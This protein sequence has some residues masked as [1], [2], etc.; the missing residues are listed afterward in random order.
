MPILSHYSSCVAPLMLFLSHCR[1]SCIASFCAIVPY[2]LS[3]LSRYYSSCVVILLVLP[4]LPLCCS[5]RFTSMMHMSRCSSCIAALVLLLPC[6]SCHVAPPA[7]YLCIALFALHLFSCCHSFHV[8]IPFK[9]LF[10]PYHSSHI[11]TPLI[12]L[13][14]HC[15]TF[16]VPTSLASIVFLMMPL[17]F[18]L[19]YYSSCV[20]SL[21]C[22]VSWYCPY[23][24]HVQVGARSFDT[25][26]N[27]KGKFHC[28]FSS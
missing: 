20:I 16:Q 14:S 6:W 24:C 18:L 11:G 22:L 3:F 17:L 1:S 8:T 26:L 2:M 23:P 5:L 4:L 21:F 9:L 25:N 12:L 27:T 19:H 10:L 28:I 15:C 7:L 13:F